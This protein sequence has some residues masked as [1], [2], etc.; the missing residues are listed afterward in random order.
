MR[1]ADSVRRADS[2]AA[3]AAQAAPEPI[4]AAPKKI[5]H[6]AVKTAAG[7]QA[8]KT[9]AAQ[10]LAAGNSGTLKISIFPSSAEVTLDGTKLS[11]KE[12]GA[13]K[14][15]PAGEHQLAAKAA[16]YETYAKT[17]AVEAGATQI[18]SIDMVKQ[19]Q[20]QAMASIHVNSY[21]WAEI[22]IDGVSQGNSPTK[23]PI[24][25]TE[26]EHTLT[27]KQ[28]GYKVHTETFTLGKG[29]LRKIKV[30]LVKE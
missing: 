28:E 17:V 13:G 10:T 30:Q 23:K 29:E 26:G 27:L 9:V 12:M 1:L 16:G 25:L 2:A 3:L 22:I 14:K 6:H 15:L 4:A 18:V 8:V 24:S 19:S 11:A 20:A 21:P 7:T 5:V